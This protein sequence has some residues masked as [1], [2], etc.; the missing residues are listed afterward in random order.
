[1]SITPKQKEFLK[2][3]EHGLCKGKNIFILA[4]GAG[5]G[6]S[7]VC[8]LLLHKLALAHP[9]VR[10]GIFRKSVAT[11]KKTTI[12]SFCKMLSD[13][14]TAESLSIKDSRALYTNG[15]EIIFSW[16]DLS[17]DPDC[18]NIKGLELSGAL[19]EEV[20]QI[21]RKFFYT[22]LSRVGRWHAPFAPFLLANCNPNVSWVKTDFY[23]PYIAEELP[24][25]VYFQESLPIDNP[26][27]TE[28][29]LQTLQSL[30]ESERQRF[31]LNI[32][33]YDSNPARLIPLDAYEKCLVKEVCA[34]SNDDIILAIDPA[35]EGKDS[36]VLCFMQGNC[37]VRWEEYPSLNEIKTAHLARLRM[38]EMRIKPQN[39]VIDS[40][41]IGAGCLN[42]LLEA[43]M[44][45][46]KFVGGQS[47]EGSLDFYS[48]K[49][50]RA[51]A[52]WLLREAF[53]NDDIRLVNNERLKSELSAISYSVDD[54]KFIRLQG[55]K[56]I[57]KILSHSPDCFDALMMANY[58]RKTNET[59]F[60][61][62][63][64]SRPKRLSNI[65][66]NF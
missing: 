2:A 31:L 49:N 8:L 35:D 45:V 23:D 39:V 4:G 38:E 56:D 60:A 7:F 34:P 28:E 30:P 44:P 26:N 53:L 18:N 51:E 37:V 3:F 43:G 33:D 22:A 11:L 24:Q 5:S 6:K 41:G 21:E 66:K 42:T 13:T 19:F 29:Y 64:T 46:N 1:M 50:L 57:K 48:F 10:F 36:T 47:A 63:L 59:R 40:V 27:L 32:W 65:V 9:G 12:P 16:A 58:L 20:N 61:R 17:K 62:I 15:S 54:D 14:K 52:A 55:K 25:N